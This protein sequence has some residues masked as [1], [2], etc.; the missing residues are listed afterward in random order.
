MNYSKFISMSML[1][2]LLLGSTTFTSNSVYADNNSTPSISKQGNN[3]DAMLEEAKNNPYLDLE[4][5]GDNFTITFTDADVYKAVRESQGLPVTRIPRANGINAIKGKLSSGDFKV[6]I[7]ANTL[8]VL[9]GSGASAISYL[10]GGGYGFVG[11]T[12]Y[13][14]INS[15]N[16]FKHGRVFVFKNYQHQY[17][18]SQ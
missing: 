18:Y 16:N 2:I 10:L 12:I 6:Y 11:S 3:M 14:L 5:D 7:T 15:E 17:W 4:I 13:N 1:S 9:K 8:N